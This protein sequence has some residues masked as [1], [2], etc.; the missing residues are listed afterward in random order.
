MRL[1]ACIQD[2]ISAR[3]RCRKSSSAFQKK[4]TRPSGFKTAILNNKLLI[5]VIAVE[6]TVP[7]IAASVTINEQLSIGVCADGQPVPVGLSVS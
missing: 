3:I 6:N 5:Y 7:G 4:K 2:E 1:S